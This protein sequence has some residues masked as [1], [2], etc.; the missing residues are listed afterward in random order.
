MNKLSVVIPVYNEQDNIKQLTTNILEELCYIQH[1][2][3]VIADDHSSD[4]TREICLKLCDQYTNITY[5]RHEKNSGQ[6]AAVY[7]GV[8]K[9]KHPVIATLDGD[10]QNPP[11]EIIKLV[12]AYQDTLNN[13]DEILFAGHR[14][15]RKDSWIKL[16]S[17][18]VANKIRQKLLRD[19]CPDSGCG[20]KLF[21]KST[22]LLLPHF[23]HMHRFLPALYKRN[24]FQVINIPISHQARKFG[25][26]KYN[27]WGRLKVGIIDM[28]AVAW[29]ARRPCYPAIAETITNSTK[30]NSETATENNSTSTITS[31][32]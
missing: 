3:I 26:S 15:N 7:S 32:Q 6:S 22:F 1:L 24:N 4:N 19:D 8:R 30:N 10:G 21:H 11:K 2:E 17:S 13:H 29:L 23:N 27:T 18:R 12:N 25:F 14:Q 16:I 9:A 28:F 5:L 20:L 31:K